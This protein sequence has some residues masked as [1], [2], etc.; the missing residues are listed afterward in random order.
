MTTFWVNTFGVIHVEAE[1][2]DQALDL[3][4]EYACQLTEA[5]VPGRPRLTLLSVDG[6]DAGIWRVGPGESARAGR[7][8][9]G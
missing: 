4:H 5:D 7:S 6:D 9:G 3:A 8:L 2:R 1:S